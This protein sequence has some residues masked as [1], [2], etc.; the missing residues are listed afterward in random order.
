MEAESATMLTNVTV[1]GF[2]RR[3]YGIVTGKLLLISPT[4]ILDEEGKPFFKARIKLDTQVIR[5]GEEV[6]P[7]VPGMTVSADIVTGEQTLL[8]YLTGP[9]YN[10]LSTSFS[11]R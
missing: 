6:F 1:N 9:V 11:E 3:R 5:D 8:Q 2:D 4:T 10:A 7:I